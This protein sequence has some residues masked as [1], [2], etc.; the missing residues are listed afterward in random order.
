M[1]M[2]LRGGFGDGR[3][4]GL[5]EECVVIDLGFGATAGS[6]YQCGFDAAFC[7]VRGSLFFSYS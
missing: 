7:T 1:M 2:K 5:L 6:T 3:V 4:E